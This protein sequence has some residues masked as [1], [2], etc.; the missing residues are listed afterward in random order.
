MSKAVLRLLLVLS[1]QMASATSALTAPML[2]PERAP[3]VELKT[4]LMRLIRSAGYEVAAKPVTHENAGDTRV[5]MYDLQSTPTAITANRTATT[6]HRIPV[7]LFAQTAQGT[8]Q[9]IQCWWLE[10]SSTG[11]SLVIDCMIPA[12][13]NKIVRLRLL[14]NR[15]GQRGIDAALLDPGSGQETRHTRIAVA[16]TIA[17][18]LFSPVQI[19]GTFEECFERCVPTIGF[20]GLVIAV[21]N[22]AGL[23]ITAG[24]T[25]GTTAAAIL[26]CLAAV[27][28]ADGVTVAACMAGCLLE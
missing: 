8:V 6:I 17:P 24:V 13:S 10:A 3:Q 25:G 14:K 7:G 27:G 4:E 2:V 16:P 9:S 1:V 22:I 26:P 19:Q 23:G 20:W 12:R 21:C 18:A 5:W 28:I 11:Y 15:D